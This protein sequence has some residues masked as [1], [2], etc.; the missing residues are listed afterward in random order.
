MN[1][2][3]HAFPGQ[4]VHEP[5]FVFARP[6]PI[7]FI[8]TALV[9]LLVFAFAIFGQFVLL[10]GFGGLSVAAVNG[11]ILFLGF[12]QLT[13]LVVFLVVILDFYFDILIVTD[14]RLVDIDQEALFFRKISELSLTD[15]QDVS[16]TVQKFVATV[17]NFG[18]VDVQT[19]GTQRHFLAENLL[20]P[21]E[22]AVIILDLADQATKGVPE[23]ERFP[24]SHI[25]AVINNDLI[26]T[27][28]GLQGR[29][30]ILPDDMR[31]IR[32]HIHP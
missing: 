27:I 18:L 22:I 8:P 14:R 26:T 11:G 2:L 15:V 13:V 29:G 31:R 16:S 1:D 9:F 23:L 25:I 6:Y 20:H 28:D 3:T 4:E 32:R 10:S 30:A 24:Q 12:F 21:R 19:A 5:V 7:A 17:F